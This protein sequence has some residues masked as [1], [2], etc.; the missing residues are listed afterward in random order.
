MVR[1]TWMMTN[2]SNCLFAVVTNTGKEI[3]LCYR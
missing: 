2:E 3:L 1:D